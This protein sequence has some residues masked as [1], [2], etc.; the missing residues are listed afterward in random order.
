MTV[1]ITQE[2][3]N[4]LNLNGLK[5]EDVA[6]SIQMQRMQGMSDD[7]IRSQY[8]DLLNTL[9]PITK[10]NY[11][12]TANIQKW[13]NEGGI[14]PFEYGKKQAAYFDNS[15]LENKNININEHAD[16]T[17]DE[18]EQLNRVRANYKKFASE[19][20]DV[21][22]R[23]K[24]I[25]NGTAS[26]G[27]KIASNF[28]FVPIHDDGKKL[29]QKVADIVSYE[30]NQD[31][32]SYNR[33][34]EE[35][36]GKIGFWEELAESYKSDE[37]I[38]VLGGFI[39]G[40][41][42][43]KK[44]ELAERVKNGED[45]RPDELEY[46]NKLVEKQKEENVRGRTFG[47]KI[48]KDLLPSLVRF[49]GEMALGNWVLKGLGVAPELA[50]TGR[51]AEGVAFSTLKDKAIFGAKDMLATGTVNTLNPLTGTSETYANN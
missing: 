44:R 10:T 22:E 16:L 42:D 26:L 33:Q 23:Y 24:R 18:L 49:G 1:N 45:I 8:D 27:D 36:Q 20:P 37:W 21:L 13:N 2:E 28:S 38:P 43:R 48:A 12:D 3:M 47:S 41:N 14:T 15:N 17:A 30:M 39:K 9:K 5:T 51:T 35:K 34:K 40:D 46:L 6:G 31:I 11:N 29:S 50:A 32:E 25:N 7:E 4:I 19:H